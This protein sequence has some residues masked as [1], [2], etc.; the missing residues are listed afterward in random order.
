MLGSEAPNGAARR[1][2][3]SPHTARSMQDGDT[4]SSLAI[5]QNFDLS[6]MALDQFY[7]WML[8]NATEMSTFSSNLNE[9]T[10]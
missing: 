8:E 2:Y 5:D 1:F 4:I 9:F 10:T 7:P 3:G 6:N